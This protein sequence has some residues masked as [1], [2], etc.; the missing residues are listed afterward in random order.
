MVRHKNVVVPVADR[1]LEG[2]THRSHNSSRSTNRRKVS[3]VPKGKLFEEPDEPEKKP[4]KPQIELN[5]IEPP[6]NP[7]IAKLLEIVLGPS[8]LAG[9]VRR[10]P[11]G[12]IAKPKLVVT[13]KASQHT[14]GS[15]LVGR[16]FS[17]VL[18]LWSMI[19]FYFELRGDERIL[20]LLGDPSHYVENAEYN[21]QL[22]NWTLYHHNL[23]ALYVHARVNSTFVGPM[24]YE[25]FTCMYPVRCDAG[26]EE[27]GCQ[28]HADDFEYFESAEFLAEQSVIFTNRSDSNATRHYF[29]WYPA[30]RHIHDGYNWAKVQ[31]RV[32]S[33]GPANA[34][35]DW[36]PEV[37][38]LGRPTNE[39]D[40]EFQCD[41]ISRDGSLGLME[42]LAAFLGNRTLDEFLGIPKGEFDVQIEEEH[43]TFRYYFGAAS[44]C[45]KDNDD[46]VACL[47][48]S[49]HPPYIC[50]YSFDCYAVELPDDEYELYANTYCNTL[51]PTTCLLEST[52]FLCELRIMPYTPPANYNASS[53][54]GIFVDST[55][56]A[57]NVSRYVDLI[58]ANYSQ[59]WATPFSTLKYWEVGTWSS[60]LRKTG[61][62]LKVANDTN[63]SQPDV[64]ITSPAGSFQAC[65]AVPSTS[66]D[67][68][69]CYT[70]SEFLMAGLDRG[71][72][73]PWFLYV[74]LP[75]HICFENSNVR[76]RNCRVVPDRGILE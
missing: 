19:G 67:L 34:S 18:V 49:A 5:L 59:V 71:E 57:S 4:P 53:S 75:H 56:T 27:G 41:V 21:W 17:I 37:D 24:L 68:T 38:E 40:I 25:N 44:Q 2:P 8:Y 60:N 1:G 15:L 43:F 28:G 11:D 48:H 14:P 76:L 54:I 69:W 22:L 50:G 46:A 55:A 63:S 65:M 12:S 52:I 64:W 23:S 10:M 45:Q 32:N 6:K 36:T 35:V 13:P 7:T 61:S 62:D 51:K 42:D 33:S 58:L 47:N 72:G 9:H 20:S 3:A 73:R 70:N 66:I 16:L 26:V 39:E 31:R 29:P 30:Y 74:R